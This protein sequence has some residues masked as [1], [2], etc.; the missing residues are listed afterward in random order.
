MSLFRL[1]V[2]SSPLAG[3]PAAA[4]QFSRDLDPLPLS[5]P[6]EARAGVHIPALDGVRGLAILLV[7]ATHLLVPFRSAARHHGDGGGM[8]V[9]HLFDAGWVGVDLFFVLSGFLITGILA[10]AKGKRHYFRSFYMR[11]SLRVFPLYY[12]VLIAACV[13]VPF[14]RPG[15]IEPGKQGWLWTYGVSLYPLFAGGAEF[16]LGNDIGL[17]FTHF[18]SL[19]VEEQFYLVW[20]LLVCFMSRPSLMRLCAWGMLLALAARVAGVKLG[21]SVP[22]LYEVTFLRMDG[23][24]AGAWVALAVRGPLGL[25]PLAAWGW[26]GLLA[27]GAV[28]GAVGVQG[29]GLIRANPLMQTV[30]FSALAVFFACAVLLVVARPGAWAVRRVLSTP[31]LCTLGKYSYGLYV[32]HGLLLPTFNR[33]WFPV[34]VSLPLTSPKFVALL[35]WHVIGSAGLSLLLAVASYHLFEAQFL[36]LKR[37]FPGAES[38]PVAAD[39]GEERESP[40]RVIRPERAPQPASRHAA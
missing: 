11:R 34:P 40:E 10:D 15:A 9:A 26:R 4:S 21:A 12:G 2:P 24:L 33:V 36:K 32:Y 17:T 6:C 20:P 28:L 37:Y 27:S 39:T 35:A 16:K 1:D 19:A 18:W 30:G 38:P 25:A 13:V 8:L 22:V 7:M 23:L 14:F 5:S 31:A 3:G 29:H